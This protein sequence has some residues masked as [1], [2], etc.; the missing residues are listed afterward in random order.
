MLAGSGGGARVK[1]ERPD[2]EPRTMRYNE[3]S[4]NY[5]EVTGARVLAG[6]AF[7][8][9]DGPD[10]TPVVMVSQA[11]ER[12]MGRPAVGESVNL[13]GKPWL[14]V[15]VVED[16]PSVRLREKIEPFVY[17]PFSQKPVEWPTFF[18]EA[19]G[20]PERVAS[21]VAA[22]MQQGAPGYEANGFDTLFSHLRS[23]RNREE[24]SAAVGGVLTLT[25][26][27]LGMAG[28]FGV[29]MYAVG[30]RA[31]EFAVRMALGATGARLAGTVFGGVTR[32]VAAGVPLG[33]FLAWSA[34]EGLQSLLYGVGQAEPALMVM[35]LAV[36]A[37]VALAAAAWPARQA[38]KADPWQALRAE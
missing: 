28:L 19:A 2:Q 38:A 22:Y 15:G 17:F 3:V 35:V 37:A 18:I 1:W 36:V 12:A 29:T 34:G 24:M 14:V 31:R 20:S 32:Y 27:L 21:R 13:G 8:V 16:G 26:L 7:T 25:S 9:S 10:T 11:F 4:A 30:R 5:F 6:R 33:A 23:A